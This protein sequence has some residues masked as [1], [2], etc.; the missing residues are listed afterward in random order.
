M[1]DGLALAQDLRQV[2]RTEDISEGCGGQETGGVAASGW[3]RW[4][5]VE[6]SKC[7]GEE[8]GARGDNL[9]GDRCTLSF[10]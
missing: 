10:F 1:G 4:W 6:A 2:L 7:E 5:T 8:R 3:R 9:K